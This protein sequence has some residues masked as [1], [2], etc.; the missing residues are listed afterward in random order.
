M[1]EPRRR[2]R[3]DRDRQNLTGRETGETIEARATQHV[4]QYSLHEVIGGVASQYWA[5]TQALSR[6]GQQAVSS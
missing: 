4:Q 2:R 6:L 3:E 5:S 1:S